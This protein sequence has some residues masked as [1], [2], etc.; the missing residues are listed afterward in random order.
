MKIFKEPIFETNFQFCIAGQES[1]LVIDPGH[2]PTIQKISEDL[3]NPITT[4]CIT[5]EHHDHIAALSEL[6]QYSPKA[7]VFGLNLKSLSVFENLAQ[8]KEIHWEDQTIQILKTPGHTQN[9][10]A[11]YFP[12]LAA[13]FSGDLI[14][15]MGCGRIFDGTFEEQF[16]SLQSLRSLPETTQIFCSHDY[17]ET[18]YRFTQKYC[19]PSFEPDLHQIPLLLKTELEQNPFLTTD[20]AEFSRLRQ[21]RNHFS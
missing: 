4:I 8:K 18:N 20:F 6:V 16:S 14:F 13:L 1:L 19:Q 17:S 21:L 2:M 11:Y 9:Q 15:Q 3:Q 5:H 10:V 7:Q 12:K